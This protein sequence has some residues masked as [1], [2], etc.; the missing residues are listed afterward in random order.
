MKLQLELALGPVLGLVL[1]PVLGLELVL[2]PEPGHSSIP[3]ILCMS[4][5]EFDL[6]K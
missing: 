4:P 1:G 6:K 2:E 3:P 5:I